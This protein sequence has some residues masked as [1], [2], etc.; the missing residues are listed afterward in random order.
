MTVNNIKQIFRQIN[1]TL[2]L[3]IS[4]NIKNLLINPKNI[5]IKYID[6]DKN[7]FEAKLEYYS[8]LYDM[9]P[10]E[11]LTLDNNININILAYLAPEYFTKSNKN[12]NL[13]KADLFSIGVILYFLSIGK[14]PFGNNVND[15]KNKIKN[16]EDKFIFENVLID[17]NLKDLIINLLKFDPN[18]RLSWSDYFKH[19]FFQ[20]KFDNNGNLID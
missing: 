3:L 12:E 19:K 10:S 18:K 1:I 6:K 20:I 5:L 2:Y 9:T 7:R 13:E 14:Y 8:F 17:N 16:N 15:I 4:N 11:F